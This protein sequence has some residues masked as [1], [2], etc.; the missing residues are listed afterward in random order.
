MRTVTLINKKSGNETILGDGILKLNLSFG[1][2]PKKSEQKIELKKV[3]AAEEYGV[4]TITDNSIGSKDSL[5]LFRKVA[6]T[7][8]L[9]LGSIGPYLA[10]NIVSRNNSKSNEYLNIFKNIT[11]DSFYKSFDLAV[12]YSSFVEIHPTITM[13][14]FKDL[15]KSSRLIPITSRSASIIAQTM[16]NKGI[17][18]PY[19]KDYNYFLESAKQNDVA[20]VIGNSLRPGCIADS[21]DKFHNYEIKLQK[22]FIELAWEKGVPVMVEVL[23]HTNP[24]HLRFA[25]KIRKTLNTPIGALGPLPTDITIGMDHVSAAIG[26]VLFGQH[27]DW[28]SIIT[29]AEHIRLP[30]YDDVVQGIT[31][32]KIAKHILSLSNGKDELLD[33]KFSELRASCDWKGMASTSI[34]P[35]AARELCEHENGACTMCGHYC[36][37]QLI[38]KK[39][40]N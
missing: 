16:V 19:F 30:T 18:N 17:E 4:D 38:K 9:P 23:G 10:C 34:N 32:S 8:I 29:P 12:K 6:R 24:Q 1:V 28:V 3:K 7:T 20:I 33:K 31:V 25:K 39:G 40:E 36:P 35:L 15:E 14:V 5:K 11:A 27:I 13:N 37:I 26:M 2:S 22:K 21:F